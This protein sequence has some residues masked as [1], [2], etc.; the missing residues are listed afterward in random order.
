MVFDEMFITKSKDGSDTI[1]VPDLDE[2]YHSIN[3]AT[4]ESIHVF[5]KNALQYCK[6]EQVNIF[7]VGFGTGLNALLT[8][9][10]IKKNDKIVNY[11]GI[12]LYPLEFKLVLNLNYPKI[13]GLNKKQT[14]FFHEMHKVHWNMDVKLDSSFTLH[15]IHGDI[16]REKLPKNVDIVYFDAF[17]PDKQPG[18]WEEKIFKKIFEVMNSK[19]ILTSYSVKGEVKRTLK[20]VGFVIEKL[21]GAPGK[22]EMLRAIKQ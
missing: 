14:K 6:K 22:R 8:W 17:A 5:I 11:H 15:K 16:H 19:G 7:E 2:H 3:G 18:I 9:L 20:K 4:T 12:E 13:L 1:F 21:P 10:D